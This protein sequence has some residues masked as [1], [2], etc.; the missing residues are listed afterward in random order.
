ML[1]YLSNPTPKVTENTGDIGYT[2][3]HL[4][5]TRMPWNERNRMDERVK[6]VA[7]LPDGEKMSVVCREFG[8]SRKTGDKIFN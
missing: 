8:I 1:C 6:F 7:R 2:L 5:D 3:L 4:G